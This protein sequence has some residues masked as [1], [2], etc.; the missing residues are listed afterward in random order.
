[1]RA[2]EL[3]HLL[4]EAYGPQGWWPAETREE[5]AIGA[6]LTQNTAWKNVEKALDN[7]RAEGLLD[8]KAI[9]KTPVEKIRELIRPA[10]FKRK[11]EY[12]RNLAVAWNEKEMEKM[13]TE[14]LR[15]YLLDIKGVGEETADS[16]L[17]Y[18]FNRP[19][20]VVDA[21][22][23]RILSRLMGL[24]GDGNI[25]E[26]AKDLSVEELQE[27]HAL[28]VEHGKRFCRKNPLCDK[29]VLRERCRYYHEVSR[30]RKTPKNGVR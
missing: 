6:V 12:L 3:L 28:L 13:G 9:R 25:R 15:S 23:R 5:M 27:L 20:F 14:E 18:G 2:R 11:A 22:T 7:L 8:M 4:L 26:W 17:L 1:M 24:E 29:C 21:Y 16:I 10:G 30:L 19:V